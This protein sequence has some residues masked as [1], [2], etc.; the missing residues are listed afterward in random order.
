M[1]THEPGQKG[2]V[3]AN[4]IIRV[5][6]ERLAKDFGE[7]RV[8]EMSREKLIALVRLRNDLDLFNK[9]ER[10]EAKLDAKVDGLEAKLDAK[11]NGLE[12]KVDELKTLL[13]E[14]LKKE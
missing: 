4:E 12:A 6:R 3:D 10:L 8:M 1:V 14:A 2:D 7:A 9:Y 5:A 11:V 13:K